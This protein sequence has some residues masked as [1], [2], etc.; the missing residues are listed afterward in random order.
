M[1]LHQHKGMHDHTVARHQLTQQFNKVLAVLVILID[2]PSPHA[3]RCDVIPAI[4]HVAS[5]MPCHDQTHQNHPTL[6]TPLLPN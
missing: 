6:T 2:I 3:T 4:P 5:Q 1:V